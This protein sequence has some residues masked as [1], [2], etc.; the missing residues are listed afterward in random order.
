MRGSTGY[1]HARGPGR[2]P[3]KELIARIGQ[4]GR[5]LRQLAKGELRNHFVPYEAAFELEE[6]MELDTTVEQ[7]DSLLFV[8]GVMLEQL[9][10]R[11]TARVLAR[12]PERASTT[13]R[14]RLWTRNR[15]QRWMGCGHPK[16]LASMISDAEY[17]ELATGH[18][19]AAEQPK[20]LASLIEAILMRERR[21]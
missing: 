10:L 9:T 5:R 6:R 8:L 20:A 1:L 2:S 3:E 15:P 13:P 12:P 14:D 16:L 18:L 11:A 7:L 17:A 4:E 21:G 19:V